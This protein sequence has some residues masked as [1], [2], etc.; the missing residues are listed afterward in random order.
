MNKTLCALI[1]VAALGAGCKTTEIEQPTP[2]SVTQHSSSSIMYSNGVVEL[3]EQIYKK[4]P[5]EMYMREQ[6]IRQQQEQM[7]R[8]SPQ[9]Y[10]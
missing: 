9:V 4:L 5:F 6:M 2:I 8:H 1:A 3:R 7:R 10:R